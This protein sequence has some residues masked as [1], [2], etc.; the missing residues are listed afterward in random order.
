ML[1]SIT[2][3]YRRGE[4][5]DRKWYSDHALREGTNIED[6]RDHLSEVTAKYLCR[7]EDHSNTLMQEHNKEAGHIE[8]QYL[9]T[10]AF[11]G[12]NVSEFT[13]TQTDNKRG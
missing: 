12:I 4:E 11:K 10:N 2:G 13:R 3:R 8:D 1:R 7:I 9:T 5:E 6:I